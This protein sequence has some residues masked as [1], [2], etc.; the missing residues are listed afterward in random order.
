[1]RTRLIPVRTRLR[2]D[3]RIGARCRSHSRAL[4]LAGPLLVQHPLNPEWLQ[5]DFAEAY[6]PDDPDGETEC[7]VTWEVWVV[8]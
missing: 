4:V 1:M 5:L 6:C 8:D 3:V 2:P 7:G